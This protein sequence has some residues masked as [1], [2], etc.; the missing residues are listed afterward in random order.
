MLR[1]AFQPISPHEVGN[2]LIDSQNGFG[3]VPTVRYCTSMMSS[4][5]RLPMPD[6]RP[7]PARVC[8][9]LFLAD[10]AV[11][12]FHAAL[13]PSLAGL[14]R[15]IILV[16]SICV[17][18]FHRLHNTMSDTPDLN[19]LLGVR[20][21]VSPRQR[22]AR[23]GA[24]R[25]HAVGH[26]QRARPPA[27]AVRRPP[28]RQHALAA[29]CRRR[30]RSSSRRRSP[31]RWRWCA[32]RSAAREAFDPR[33]T[34]RSLRVYMTDVGET[35]LLPGADAPP[36]GARPGDAARDRAAARRRARGAAG[37]RRH[38]PRGRLP[39][40]AARQDPP[41]APVRGALRLHDAARPSARPR[42]R[43]SRSRNSSARAMC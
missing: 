11:P 15:P 1:I 43:R 16:K 22:D 29:C 38:R 8:A 6:G 17:N 28:V 36:A 30:A 19:L 24:D 42:A 9:L 34:T 2:S 5:G 7:K 12:G 10:D 40:A 20:G 33:R 39:A 13:L 32:A 14:G 26:E 23:G 41:R 37:D 21:D 4:A 27:H 25:P 3:V 18:S 31:R 35:V